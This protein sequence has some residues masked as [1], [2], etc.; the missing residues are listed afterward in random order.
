MDIRELLQGKTD[1]LEINED[2]FFTKDWYQNTDIIELKNVHFTGNLK[3]YVDDSFVLEGEYSGDMILKDSISLE[4]VTY[5]FSNQL[6]EE[7]TEKVKN[8]EIDDVMKSREF[9]EFGDITFTEMTRAVIKI[10]DGC[11]RFCSYC[12]IPYARGRVRSRRPQNII[13]EISNISKKGIKEVVITGI[14]IA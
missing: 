7:V 4:D 3:R 5:H 8:V 6:E 9:A 1:K 11:D 12:I 2:F 13:S 10:Q 14:H